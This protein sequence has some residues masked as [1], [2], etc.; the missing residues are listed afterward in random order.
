MSLPAISKH[1]RCSR[2]PGLLARRKDGASTTAGSSP[3]PMETASDWIAHYGSS[4]RGASTP[5]SGT[6]RFPAS[7]GGETWK[8]RRQKLS[9][10]AHDPGL[11]AEGLPGVDGA[12]TDDAVVRRGRLGDEPLP[13]RPARGR[14]LP[15]RGRDRRQEWAIWG[16]YLEVR[17]PERLVYTWIWKHDYGF[18]DPTGDTQV[19]V[20]FRD[21]GADTEI[22]LT[23][24]RFDSVQAREDHAEGWKTCLDRI[25]RLLANE[26]GG[27]DELTEGSGCAL[28]WHSW[29]RRPAPRPARRRRMEPHEVARRRLEGD[30]GGPARLGHATPSSPTAP[31]LMETLDGDHGATMIT[32]YAPDGAAMLATHYCAAG[33]Q[34]RMRA[35]GS[36]DG[37]SLAFEFVDVSNAGRAEVMRRLV[38]TFV[39][40]DHFHQTLDLARRG[41]QGALERVR[42]HAGEVMR[43]RTVS[44]S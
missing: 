29:S 12:R 22:L 1:L 31:R 3:Q 13:D 20:E 24:D 39:D 26:E 16:T 14:P 10:H 23:H 35:T 38:V 27:H 7:K 25:E 41:R 30:G 11:A 2:T 17:P 19:T 18:G 32:M 36:P 40:A 8:R 6:W 44:V 9:G 43:P 21:S 34:P 4:G 37:K 28:A 5:S 33:N 15:V 42:V